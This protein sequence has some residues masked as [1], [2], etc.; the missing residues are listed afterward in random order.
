MASETVTTVKFKYVLPSFLSDSV[1]S[2]SL[3][4]RL[5]FLVSA[6]NHQPVAAP[7]LL[8]LWDD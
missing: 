5:W 2:D 4:T 8:V 7:L 3:K 6:L 1:P